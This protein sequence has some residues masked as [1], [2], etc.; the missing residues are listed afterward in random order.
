MLN[1]FD[2]EEN[3]LFKKD[4]AWQTKTK[5]HSTLYVHKI[6]PRRPARWMIGMD[7]EEGSGNS[8]LTARLDEEID[9]WWL[10]KIF[11][12][13]DLSISEYHSINKGNLSIYVGHSINKENLSMYDGHSVIKGNLSVYE[14]D[15]LNK[16]KL[17][18]QWSFNK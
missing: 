18:L 9:T 14:G 4:I 15:S 12:H 10:R 2:S 8:V 1:I 17:C 3:Y 16:R 6:Q 13:K 7:G 5:I 11:C